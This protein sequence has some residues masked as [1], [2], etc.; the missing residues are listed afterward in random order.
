MNYFLGEIS[1]NGRGEEEFK[2][3]RED[4][5]DWLPKISK[6]K[7]ERVRSLENIQKRGTPP[8]GRPYFF[9][10]ICLPSEIALTLYAFFVCGFPWRRSRCTPQPRPASSSGPLAQ[11]R[12]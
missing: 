12:I 4:N 3:A 11:N 5:F 10:P 1:E 7:N 9:N 6:N 8:Q 2:I